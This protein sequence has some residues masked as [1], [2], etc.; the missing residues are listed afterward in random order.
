MLESGAQSPFDDSPT[1]ATTPHRAL[2]IG[3]VVST[4][5]VAFEVTALITA[6]PTASDELSGDALYGATLAAY[7]LANIIG[8]VATGEQ[9]D[10]RGP[11]QPF[12]A[13]IV[14]FIA[15]LLLASAAITMPTLLLGRVVQGLGAGGL[16]PVSFAVI[17]RVWDT[18]GQARMFA[19]TSASWILPSLIA[20]GLAGWTSTTVGW[21]WIFLGIVPFA[22]LTGV[23]V[24]SAMARLPLTPVLTDYLR[25][26]RLATA[27]RL[28]A[29]VGALIAGAQS[30]SL[31]AAG[32][33]TVI[34]VALA[35]PAWRKLMPAGIGRARHGLAAILACRTLATA[36]FLGVDS[37]VPLAA[38]RIHGASPTIQGFVIIGAALAWSGGSAIAARRRAMSVTTSATVGFVL[39]TISIVAI[40]PVLSLNWPLWATFVTW[41]I[42]GFGMGLLFVPT[43]V[44]VMGYAPDGQ[45][46]ELGS[47]IN[48]ADSLGFSLM[49]G[50]GGATV[51]I[52]DRTEWPLDHALG[53]NF[54]VAVLLAAI[55]IGLSR[56]IAARPE[57]RVS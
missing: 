41:G 4:S 42:G 6:L 55:G 49:G 11:R 13:C 25:P 1:M 23:V 43:A 47:Q 15:G 14:T 33:L 53:V 3:L 46:G 35:L 22:A 9:I 34:G 48:L 16:A 40:T 7:T 54:A 8:L 44:T 39:L 30:R 51:A 12:L 26:R 45:E 57:A 18:A 2:A 52:A 19:W 20:P 24:S 31:W 10:R 17:R 32:A 37:F 29:G 56:R 5:L 28:T 38:D 21:R 27:V 36:A 50:F